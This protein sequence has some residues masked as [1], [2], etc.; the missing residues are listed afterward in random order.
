MKIIL[1]F[2]LSL[3]TLAAFA[4]GPILRTPYTV[5]TAP[6]VTN[7][8][9]GIVTNNAIAKTNGFGYG[10]SLQNATNN[11]TTRFGGN[12]KGIIDIYDTD[13]SQYFRLEAQSGGLTVGS[14]DFTAGQ[15]FG[16]ASA[17]SLTSGTI[18]DARFP[19]ILPAV[20]GSQLTGISG[21]TGIATNAGTGIGNTL[22]NLNMSGTAN[23]LTVSPSNLIWFAEGI[24]SSGGA[25]N[26]NR[27]PV[28]FGQTIGIPGETQL[29]EP[30]SNIVTRVGAINVDGSGNVINTNMMSASRNWESGW[31]NLENFT[32]T[33]LHETWNSPYTQWGTNFGWRFFGL[34][35]VFNTD[36]REFL[37][38]DGGYAVDVF[39]IENP[40]QMGTPAAA[41]YV[42][43]GDTTNEASMYVRGNITAKSIPGVIQSVV[44]T[45]GGALGMFDTTGANGSLFRIGAS[46]NLRLTA[47]SGT[48]LG[49][50]ADFEG[51]SALNAPTNTFF[52]TGASISNGMVRATNTATFGSALAENNGFIHQIYLWKS[53]GSSNAVVFSADGQVFDMNFSGNGLRLNVGG[54]HYL[55]LNTTQTLVNKSLRVNDNLSLDANAI[56]SWDD[57]TNYF[58]LP[59]GSGSGT[60]IYYVTPFDAQHRIMLGN[61]PNFMIAW[62]AGSNVVYRVDSSGNVITEGNVT[63]AGTM[64][65]AGAKIT[66]LGGSGDK[67]IGVDNDGNVQHMNTASFSTLNVE[68]AYLTNVYVGNFYTPTNQLASTQ[69]DISKASQSYRTNNNIVLTGLLGVDLSNTNSQWSRIVITNSA[70]SG[71]PISCTLNGG[72]FDLNGAGNPF[73]IT[74]KGML[75]VQ[76]SAWDGTN[77]IWEGR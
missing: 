25:T 44:S 5:N 60:N 10:T 55:E 39:K 74:N 38:A 21:G 67:V 63:A 14:A 47:D 50:T 11:G 72:F 9:I 22:S 70:G 62:D 26:K 69:I 76:R 29:D 41:W 13:D 43:T 24:G 36:T 59:A 8:I 68:N 32:Q 15:F 2:F 75:Y 12:A 1:T 54:G 6:V 45:W 61:T 28:V 27:L 71:T 18:P 17:S 16:S 52:G 48:T 20:D 3:V 51:F 56:D 53:A 4:Q 33:E 34:N 66:A 7:I 57:V 35:F 42:E 19:A 31:Q 65:S 64:Q 46:G 49:N 30:R 23:F 40:R 77:Y 37:S 73:W 58:T